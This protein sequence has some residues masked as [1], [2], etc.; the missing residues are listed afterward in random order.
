MVPLGGKNLTPVNAVVAGLVPTPLVISAEDPPL[1]IPPCQS[2]TL[3]NDVL[4]GCRTNIVKFILAPAAFDPA[5]NISMYVF[6][7]EARAP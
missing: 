3:H 1:A 5:S 7:W 4:A 6:D 2:K